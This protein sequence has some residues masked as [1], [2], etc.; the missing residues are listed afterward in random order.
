VEAVMFGP[1]DVRHAQLW[2]AS[3]NPLFA[4]SGFVNAMTPRVAPSYPRQDVPKGQPLDI[5]ARA[6]DPG[7]RV[8][9]SK[10]QI[11]LAGNAKGDK[12]MRDIMGMTAG[13]LARGV[14]VGLDVD[15]APTVDVSGRTNYTEKNSR[16]FG[17]TT[18]L[19][20]S[21]HAI[22]DALAVKINAHQSFSAKVTKNADGS[23]V[24]DLARA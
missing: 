9:T 22:A 18:N 3:M 7:I 8:T 2:A 4:W 13:Y 15:Q 1:V 17:V 21:A 24:I 14:S 10:N 23:A 6:S 20:Q 5:D 19:G 16:H 11:V 12:P